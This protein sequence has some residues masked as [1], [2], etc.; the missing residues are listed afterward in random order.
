MLLSC[1]ARPPRLALLFLMVGDHL[2][3]WCGSVEHDNSFSQLKRHNTTQLLTSPLNTKHTMALPHNITIK[4]IT[5]REWE[6]LGRCVI[7]ALLLIISGIETNPG[8]SISNLNICHVNIN[9]IPSK[10]DELSVFVN[11]N[12]VDILMASETKLDDSVHPSRYELSDFHTPYLNNRNRD[13][14]GT[15]IYTR[16][17]LAVKRLHDL[18]LEGEDW[19]WAKVSQ[20]GK[21]IVICSLYLPPGLTVDRLEEF[22]IRFMESIALANSL[23]PL[24]IFVLGDFNTGNI[25]LANRYTGQTGN[26]GITPFD[27]MFSNTLETLEL[28]QLI[29]SP[30]RITET[31]AN[32][33]DLAITNNTD[34]ITSVGTLSSFGKMDHL[35]IFVS[36]NLPS[37]PTPSQTRTIWDYSRLDA[38]KLTRLLQTA[39]W[40][41]MLSNDIDVATEKFTFAI[42]EAAH[43]AIPRKIIR[44]RPRDKP[45]MTGH[46]K[47]HMTKRDRLF[48]KAKQTD[49]THDWEAW[50]LQ[51][52][53]VTRLNKDFKDQHTRQQVHKLL[54]HRHNPYQ[55]HKILKQ[56]ITPRHCTG[57][58]PLE[59]HSQHMAT[60]D[61]EKA[62]ALNRYFAAQT[63]LL[64][65][66]TLPHP[67]PR[68][69]PVPALNHITITEQEV[70]SALNSLN[71][72]KSTGPDQLPTKILKMTAILIAEP[73]TKLFN[74]S[75]TDSKFPNLWKEANISPIFKRKGSASDPQNYRPISL[76]CC[77]SKILEKIV[78][79]NIYNHLTDNLLLSDMQSGYRPH[80]N[81]QMQLTYM[82]D[83][84]YNSLDKGHD[85]TAVYLDV[86]KYFDRI[87]HDG[88]LFKCEHDYSISGSLL[89]WL[90][91]YLT[92]RRQKVKIGNTFSTVLTINA[93]CPQ[94]SILGPLLA[95]LYL[96]GLP[97][98]LTNTALF[99]ADDISLYT[100][101]TPDTLTQAQNSLQ[102]DLNTI[103]SYG[104]Q[105]A[106][107]FSP[108]KTLTQTFSNRTHHISPSISF[109]GQPIT[110][111]DVH[112]H[113]G[114]TLSSDLRFHAHVNT[115]VRKVNIALSPLYPIAK[116]LP[117]QVLDIIYK[118]YIRPHFDYCDCIYDGHLTISDELRLERLQNRAARIVTSTLPRTSTNKLRLELGWDSLKTRRKV[119]RL[120]LYRKLKDKTT[121]IPDY[122]TNMIPE[123]RRRDTGRV[124]RNADQLTVPHSRT[125]SY[126]RSF[127]PNTSRNWN[128]LPHS[129]QS[130]QSRK[131]FEQNVKS[132]HGIPQPSHYFTLGTKKGNTLHTQLRMG[133]SKLNAH[134]YS[135]QKVTT[136]ACACGHNQENTT[137]FL[138]YCPLFATAR[139]ILTNQLSEH[140]HID[141]QGL[142]DTSKTD[143]LLFGQNTTT[144]TAPLISTVFQNFLENT[145][146]LS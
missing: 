23:S 98:Q 114:L 71:P 82:T 122:I 40:E 18:E 113:L 108:S 83:S 130:C 126:Q 2:A 65:A 54:A 41:D 92:D 1:C 119:H 145:S 26:S 74:K 127:I 47:Y 60:T 107:T 104:R 59:T 63:Q 132:L 99:Y 7:T 64:N 16:N 139:F 138:F 117:R 44:I 94:G 17:N 12:N 133:M 88:L 32:L 142:S 55:Y 96:D 66:P 58:P 37:S 6:T 80:H 35:P 29:T 11:E 33:R 34:I 85:F 24:A 144:H 70:L 123:P 109:T 106:I 134:Q 76:L 129:I 135:I 105:W 141:F 72:H 131:Q 78:F 146:R 97:N 81:T 140:L 101:Y 39:D 73:L 121:Q 112:K 48:K 116:F 28:T 38:D 8:P 27:I 95:L 20:N 102:N 19:V 31:V 43:K 137:H 90:K 118:T 5:V 136:P 124:L 61:D 53:F 100:S 77:L 86:T 56:T 9:S 46:L 84:L 30:T 10:I 50:R 87:W 45:W 143:T 110:K 42:L 13:G 14:G 36:T 3:G 52:N 4:H 69:R 128:S 75:L 68:P 15:A 62:T 120:M 57:I 93:G 51:R 25:F 89:N 111:T 22:N 91:S 103:E 49:L 125:S 67:I 21:S 115:I 79:R